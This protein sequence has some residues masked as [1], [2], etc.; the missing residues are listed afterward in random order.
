MYG[1]DYNCYHNPPAYPRGFVNLLF[2]A[3]LIPT[4][5]HAERDNS[6][7]PG[8]AIIHKYVVFVQNV[9]V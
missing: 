6:P 7:P 4:P 3:G 5:G 1:S 9:F 8:R 2:L